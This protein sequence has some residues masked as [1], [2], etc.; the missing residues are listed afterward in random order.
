MNNEI[1]DE[2][3][4]EIKQEF[5]DDKKLLLAVAFSEANNSYIVDIAQGSSVAETAFGVSV[6]ARC[7]VRDG[8]IK[9]TKEF[10]DL[11]NKY[12]GDPQ[13]TEVKDGE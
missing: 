7:L 3:R 5:V 9:E 11:V 1:R 2:I 10:V 13:F 6:I 12:L 4:N 8:I